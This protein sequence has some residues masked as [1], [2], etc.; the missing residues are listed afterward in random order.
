LSSAIDSTSDGFWKCVCE[1]VCPDPGNVPGCR[2]V[3][4]AC[5]PDEDKPK[6]LTRRMAA[7]VFRTKPTADL[8]GG[9]IGRDVWLAWQQ[10]D[11]VLLML[12]KGTLRSFKDVLEDIAYAR[13]RMED[14]LH[15]RDK[16]P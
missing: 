6:S 4:V 10:L 15:H 5:S 9:A 16:T 3:W 12:E 1:F 14:A 8:G 13:E 2:A 11:D 7:R